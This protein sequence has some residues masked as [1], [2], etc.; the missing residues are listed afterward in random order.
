MKKRQRWFK[1]EEKLLID[2]INNNVDGNPRVIKMMS[3]N[4]QRSEFS[5]IL[6]VEAIRVR[7]GL[8][9]IWT[10]SKG[11]NQAWISHLMKIRPPK[12]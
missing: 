9:L 2:A 11:G 4:L 10:G 7:Q 8:P 1:S 3:D 5:V 6:R 12:K